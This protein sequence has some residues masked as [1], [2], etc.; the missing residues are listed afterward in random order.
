MPGIGPRVAMS[1][2]PVAIEWHKALPARCLERE[3]P[4]LGFDSGGVWRVVLP[5]D[6]AGVGCGAVG[7]TE[8]SNQARENEQCHPDN[9]DEA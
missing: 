1:M 3:D 4:E 9:R 6:F 5:G 8:R 7:L 2:S